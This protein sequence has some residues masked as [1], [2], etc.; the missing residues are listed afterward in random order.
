LKHAKI[1][2]NFIALSHEERGKR[3]GLYH[4]NDVPPVHRA[5]LWKE[6]DVNG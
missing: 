4:E 6:A 2:D 5:A 1:V 3:S